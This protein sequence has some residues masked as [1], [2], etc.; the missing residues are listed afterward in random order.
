MTS[1]EEILARDGSLVYKTHGQ[2]MEPLLRQDRDLV[3]ISATSSRLKKNDV[4]LY[5]R[6]DKY[7][8]HR[9]IRVMPDHYLI[10]GDNTF[11]LEKVPD[12]AVLGVMTAFK[13]KG[14]AYTITDRS[15]QRY[16]CFWN[17]IYPFRY[18]LFRLRKL[19]IA[20]ARRTGLLPV[21]KKLI[22]RK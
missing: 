12:S 19:L 20:A 3:V 2:S 10:R 15:Y 11:T 16:I 4:A 1:F 5:R 22:R 7:V 8:L 14:R 9:V 18:S 6:G 13:R 21:I 17:T